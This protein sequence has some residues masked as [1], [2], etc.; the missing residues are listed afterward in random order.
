VYLSKIEFQN[1]RCFKSES[2]EFSDFTALVG[3]NNNGKST[4]LRALNIFFSGDDKR[5]NI[6]MSDFSVSSH[7]SDLSI[8]YEFSDVSGDAEVDLSHYVRNNKVIFEIVA[9][10]NAIGE[11]SA[12]CRGIRYGLPELAPFFE[13]QQ[14]KERRQIYDQLRT[15]QPQLPA[16]KNMEQATNAVREYEATNTERHERI[17][18]TES[19]YGA[20]GP[21]PKL[22][23]YV[24]WIYVPAIKD[25]SQESIEQKNSAFAK[26]IA[27]A[28][29]AKLDFQ[30]QLNEI[31][32]STKEKISS[33]F[34]KADQ[35]L[36]D[37]SASLNS[38]FSELSTTPIRIDL[39]WTTDE[40]ISIR[41]PSIHSTFID[42]PVVGAP[43]NFGH[44]IQR[45][46]IV[47][48]LSLAAKIQAS[49][50]DFHLIL[51]IEEP[52][53]YQHPPQA[54]FLSNALATLAGSR[55]QV[56]VT[57]HSPYFISGQT[58]ESVRVLKKRDNSTKAYSWSIDEQRAYCAARKNAEPV[59]AQAA[60]SGI[61]KTMLTNIPEMF[62]ATKVVFVEGIEDEAIISAYLKAKNMYR[63][64][65]SAGGHFVPV[66]GKQ[67]M[68]MLIALSRGFNIDCY[69][70]FDFDSSKSPLDRNNDEIRRYAEDIKI[71]IPVNL[72]QDFS[73]QGFFAFEDNIQASIQASYDD[74]PELARSVAEEWGWD[75][76]KMHKDPMLL[77]EVVNRSIAQGAALTPLR[78]LCDALEVFWAS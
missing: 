11:V 28:V 50:D 70:V 6:T 75:I 58:F 57:T 66:G 7:R 17:P 19:A 78:A 30:E 77:T 8:L 71:E 65:L 1:F 49:E 74:W 18:S 47:A 46:Y 39:Q 53:L 63:N 62:F 20:T 10:S 2:I 34:S 16:W 29:R 42:G 38:E 26:L 61:D 59:G 60:L 22:R 64:F 13:A 32:A 35:I 37:V 15:D 33:L 52:E 36:G 48:L 5:N 9:S 69:C 43:E 72:T 24:D 76:S 73:S 23:R 27:Y 51:G 54:R 67:K 14:A 12:K 55:A 41:E 31:K 21:V 44:G 56:L 45:T 68:P 40:S 3:P 25:A 4:V